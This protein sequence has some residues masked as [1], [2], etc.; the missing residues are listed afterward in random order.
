MAAANADILE[1]EQF[2][3]WMKQLRRF[4]IVGIQHDAY[5]DVRNEDQNRDY[6]DTNSE[7]FSQ[8]IN[9]LNCLEMLLKNGQ[10]GN[11]VKL[12]LDYSNKVM[13]YDPLLLILAICAT[14]KENDVSQAAYDKLNLICNIPSKLFKFLKF[15]QRIITVGRE[16]SPPLPQPRKRKRS[17]DDI[18]NNVNVLNISETGKEPSESFDDSHLPTA[19]RQKRIEKQI[20]HRNGK[21][22]VHTD[23]RKSLGWGRMRRRAIANFY[24]DENK[25]PSRLLYLCSKYK[26][27][28]NWSHREALK[29]SHPKHDQL[30]PDR[31]L[32][33]D[34]CKRGFKEN[35][36]QGTSLAGTSQETSRVIEK[37]K[38]LDEVSKLKPNN[39]GDE[40]KLL[41]YLKEY[42]VRGPNVE[43]YPY[44]FGTEQPENSFHKKEPFHL[45]REHIPTGFLKLKRV[46]VELLMDM[47][48]FA[49]LR[50]LG[51]MSSIPGMFDGNDGIEK[52][53]NIL[54][55]DAMI[56]A[57]IH[58]ISIL[59]ALKVYSSGK[60]DKGKLTW[61]PNDSIVEALNKAFFISF[62][63][64]KK[65]YETRKKYLICLD[66]SETM[67]DTDSKKTIT[68]AEISMAMAMATK[69]FEGDGDVNTL[70]FIGANGFVELKETLDNIESL[71]EA[72]NLSIALKE[73]YEPTGSFNY[74]SPL[75]YADTLDLNPDCVIIYTDGINNDASSVQ[76]Y[77]EE[78]N[79]RRGDTKL[80]LCSLNKEILIHDNSENIL[81]IV[82]FDYTVPSVIKEFVMQ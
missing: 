78:F 57:N 75:I 13:N 69:H 39:D 40:D 2:I 82:G 12:L 49:M 17:I 80:I 30:S 34:Y 68:P 25:D 31:K 29:Y 36:M 62:K 18:S 42:S 74:S 20:E 46:W 27:R 4:L 58:P 50:N 45:V 23:G 11:V 66:I 44:T 54:N 32:V 79:I 1:E 47:P 38:V 72:L 6:A 41:N 56:R 19:K 9:N 16:T 77:L 43:S 59:K 28:C 24:M 55:S 37:I 53:T 48:I 22:K 71:D 10:H 67:F 52:I 70:G 14:N 65:F 3:S 51:K 63:K 15:S 73:A 60:G 21:K 61:T 8:V 81:K 26:K 7:E 5:Y 35:N 64:V 76:N 33:I